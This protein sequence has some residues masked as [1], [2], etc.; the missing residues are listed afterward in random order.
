MGSPPLSERLVQLLLECRHLVV[1]VWV[2][3]LELKVSGLGV[4]VWIWAHLVLHLLEVGFLGV[5]R[6]PGVGFG[7]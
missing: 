1:A 5:E 7:G 4:R 3:L 2:S 6:G